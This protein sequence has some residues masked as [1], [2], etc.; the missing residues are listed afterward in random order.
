MLGWEKPQISSRPAVRKPDAGPR[1]GI[2]VALLGAGSELRCK[3][4][5]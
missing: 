5:I 4:L 3:T 1:P 2:S